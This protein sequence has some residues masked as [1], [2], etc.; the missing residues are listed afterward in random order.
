MSPA[1]TDP[2]ADLIGFT[3]TDDN[4]RLWQVTGTWPVNEAYVVCNHTSRGRPAPS[5]L[6]VA[7]QVRV[8]RTLRRAAANLE[9]DARDALRQTEPKCECRGI[10]HTREC[11][12]GREARELEGLLDVEPAPPRVSAGGV[13]V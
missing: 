13:D 7:E 6:R 1:T 4:G 2:N 9:R 8:A 11:S 5:T 3:F 12:R 10:G